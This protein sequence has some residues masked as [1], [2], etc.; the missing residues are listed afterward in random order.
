[1]NPEEGIAGEQPLVC[2]HL[3]AIRYVEGQKR[4]HVLN[5]GWIGI[6]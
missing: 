4:G 2:R 1:M 3:S 5:A 6:P